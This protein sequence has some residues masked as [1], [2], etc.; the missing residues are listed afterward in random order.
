MKTF[1]YK[2]RLA[3]AIIAT[4]SFNA[5]AEN[6][7]PMSF[8]H[9][10]EISKAKE[11]LLKPLDNKELLVRDAQS[12]NSDGLVRFAEPRQVS[13]KPSKNAWDYIASPNASATNAANVEGVYI[14]RK[15]IKSPGA[16][17]I[18][19]GFGRFVMPEG[20]SLHMY[21]PD[22]ENLVRAFT[23][24]DNEEH[25]QLWT[26]MLPGDTVVIEVNIPVDQLDALE[27]ELTSVNHGYVGS[28]AQEV[29]ES[30]LK[31]GSCN[32]DVVCSEGD[33]WRDQIRS[34]AAYST[35]GSAFCSGSAINN[36]A[37]DGRGFFLTA[38]HC[39]INAQNAPS[40][41]VYWNYENSTCRTP[42]SSSSGS[43]GDGT[44]NEFNTGAIFRAG[45]GPTDMTLVELDD[46]IDPAH[47]VYLS[48]WNASSSI[49][50]SAVGI[51][52]PNVEEKR[53]SFDNDPLSLS[54]STHLQ[55]NDWDVGTTEPGSSGSPLYDQD[56]RIVGQLTGGRAA[57]GND[58]FDIYGW[59]N[60][61]WNGGGTDSTRLSTWLDAAGTGE[62]FIDGREATGG[63]A[64]TPTPTPIP[65]PT[66]GDVLADGV[67]VTGISGATNSERFFTVNVP[68]GT[69]SLRVLMRGGSGDADLYVK[70]GSKPTLNDFDCRPFRSGNDETCR[71]DSPQAGTY[72][73]LIHGFSSFSDTSVEARY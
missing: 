13:I 38:D 69:Q 36:T 39:G 35:G 33:D 7:G 48:G 65:T 22:G 6:I 10:S 3:A 59:V 14:W 8:S 29:M 25:G 17:S 24:E 61:S 47:E 44:L 1:K 49:P 50:T 40:M 70:A 21:T 26:P 43:R 4:L 51:H 28:S 72:H 20:G 53:I 5:F 42:G 64:P 15:V 34:V 62:L 45:Y 41:V 19:L 54:G 56:K 71:I 68:A 18:N 31:S 67:P 60:V 27:L 2:S 46:P 32:V 9:T 52:H 57:C 30:F 37:N 55:V 16:R 66:P 11:L 73:V 12:F 63:G 23:S 58:E